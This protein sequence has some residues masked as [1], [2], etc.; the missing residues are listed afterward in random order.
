[1]RG[2]LSLFFMAV[3]CSTG[4]WAQD[5]TQPAPQET[6]PAV[7]ETTPTEEAP[8]EVSTKRR[9][10]YTLFAGVQ[11]G[12]FGGAIAT[13]NAE[14]RKVN[15]D[16]WPLPTYGAVIT[17]PF[18]S[19]S[20]I[21]GRLDLGVWTTGTRTRPYEF[22]GQLDN[23]EGY[24]IERYTYFS[25]TPYINLSGILIGMGIDFPMKGEMWNPNADVENH[26]VDKATMK[27]A[28][29]FR[30]GGSITAW[31]TDL[32]ILNIELIAYYM[33]TG[34]YA[35]DPMVE[36]SSMYPYGTESDA[37]GVRTQDWKT[38]AVKNL[39]PAGAHL[40]ISYQFKVGL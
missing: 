1:M 39:T 28:L 11:A 17:A 18:G 29:D 14:G 26:I 40:G 31:E 19:G 23:W 20:R 7:E 8:Q 35:D 6:T 5:T 38:G 30:I 13:E 4:L 21:R 22:F 27:T 3:V 24:F 32:G 10:T 9:S 34:V 25:V 16:Y 12:L 33:F 2:I 36:G 37:R 15:P